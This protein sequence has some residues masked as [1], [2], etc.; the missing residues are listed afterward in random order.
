MGAG[1]LTAGS[2]FAAPQVPTVIQRAVRGTGACLVI[3][4]LLQVRCYSTA[5]GPGGVTLFN[6][7]AM[8]HPRQTDL[9]LLITPQKFTLSAPMVVDLVL[10]GGWRV[11]MIALAVRLLQTY[12]PPRCILA[13]PP[14]CT[15]SC[16][17]SFQSPCTAFVRRSWSRRSC[18][19]WRPAAASQA[20]QPTAAQARV[21]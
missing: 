4:G 20:C 17:L 12:R 16:S 1:G 19:A 2:G 15:S 3:L 18:R 7:M 21:E 9:T 6:T 5:L 8:I 13:A 10:W 14:L 11:G